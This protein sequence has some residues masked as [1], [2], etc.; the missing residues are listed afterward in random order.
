MKFG[1]KELHDIRI[2]LTVQLQNKKFKIVLRNKIN[3]RAI[4]SKAAKRTRTYLTSNLLRHI[5]EKRKKNDEHN[6]SPTEKIKES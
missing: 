4:N 3:E 5:R 2:L 1:H 6:S